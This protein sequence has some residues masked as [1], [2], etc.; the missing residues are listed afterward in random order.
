MATVAYDVQVYMTIEICSDSLIFDCA[1]D[2]IWSQLAGI[3]VAD[4]TVN[5]LEI[6]SA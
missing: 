3:D 2:I 5:D 6:T 1:S 4:M